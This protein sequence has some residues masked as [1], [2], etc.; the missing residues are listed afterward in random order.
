MILV[1]IASIGGTAFLWYTYFDIKHNLDKTNKSTLLWESV[2][3]E[4]A[5]LWF[6]I[7]ATIITVSF[8]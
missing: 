6:S 2:R 8:F 4:H 5:F 1:T 7:I 3:N